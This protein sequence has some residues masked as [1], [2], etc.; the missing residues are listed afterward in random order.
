MCADLA[1][2]AA[3]SLSHVIFCYPAYVSFPTSRLQ[4]TPG[5]NHSK[6]ITQY[7][8]PCHST[9]RSPHFPPPKPGPKG[10]PKTE[11]NEMKSRS[12]LLPWKR[13][14]WS[15]SPSTGPS[16]QESRALCAQRAR[17]QLPT[18]RENMQAGGAEACLWGGRVGEKG[19]A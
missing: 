1:A 4:T 10:T 8:V 2:S 15:G 12:L 17:L 5:T 9:T 18:T 7:P 16:R 6:F 19:T 13:G 3:L 14:P 11:K